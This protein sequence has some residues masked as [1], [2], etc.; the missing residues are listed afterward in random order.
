MLPYF[1][2]LLIEAEGARLLREM[3]ANQDPAR[4]VAKEAAWCLPAESEH[5][6]AEINLPL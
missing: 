1:L 3:Q 5:P 2:F 4:S 6:V